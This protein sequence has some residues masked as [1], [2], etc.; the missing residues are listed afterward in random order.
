MISRLPPMPFPV[1]FKGVL[2][3]VHEHV[4][5][6]STDFKVCFLTGCSGVL[7]EGAV[8]C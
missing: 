8:G 3:P 6:R 1:L 4:I 7:S 5:A 2:H